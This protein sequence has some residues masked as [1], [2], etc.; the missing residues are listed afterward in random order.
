M[1]NVVNKLLLSS[2]TLI[3]ILSSCNTSSLE[4]EQ[5]KA[6]LENADSAYIAKNFALSQQLL[7]SL[8]SN[9][10]KQIDVQRD[11]LHLRPKVIEGITINEIENCDS[12][13]AQLQQEKFRLEEYFTYINSPELVDGYYVAKS[14]S[15]VNLFSK[16]GIQARI[17]PEGEFYIISSLTTKP[18]KHTSIS[19]ISNNERVKTTDIKYD[20]DRNY[21]SGSTE[22]IT[23]VGEECDTLGYFASHNRDKFITLEFNGQQKYKTQ[24]TKSD[25]EALANTYDMAK[26][27]SQ[28]RSTLLRKEMLEHKLMI[29]RDQI[30][31]TMR[32]SIVDE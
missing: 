19:L 13:I 17:S 27:I 7:D 30:A 24:L 28:L 31:R 6:L 26:I 9:F 21:R 3:G 22:M 10:P 1:C 12:L 29:A 20:G 15:N 14:I 18:I 16:T 23:F 11:A 32:D 2:I 25:I 8:Q 5:A 4:Q